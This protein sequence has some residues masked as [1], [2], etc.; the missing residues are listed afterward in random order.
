M[1]MSLLLK[2]KPPVFGANQL[3]E[4]K[5]MVDHMNR[6]GFTF[7]TH[8]VTYVVFNDLKFLIGGK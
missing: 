4:A 2:K 7:W 6:V 1:I 8:F 3:R 5:S